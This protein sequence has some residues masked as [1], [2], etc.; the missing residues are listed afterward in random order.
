MDELTAERW[1]RIRAML[2]KSLE[3]EAAERPALL[4]ELCREDEGLRRDRWQS[5]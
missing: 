1:A 2:A 4:E 5:R 3:I